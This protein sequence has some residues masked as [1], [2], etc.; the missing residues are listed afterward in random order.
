[1]MVGFKNAEMVMYIDLNVLIE[2]KEIISYVVNHY[3]IYY[4]V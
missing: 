2:S 1:M 3:Q 4:F